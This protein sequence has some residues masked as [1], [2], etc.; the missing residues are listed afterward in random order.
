MLFEANIHVHRYQVIMQAKQCTTIERGRKM[1]LWL[2]LSSE[3]LQINTCNEIRSL[4]LLVCILEKVFFF[5]SKKKMH[6]VTQ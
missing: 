4:D 1:E 3:F 2:F 6:I 5:Q